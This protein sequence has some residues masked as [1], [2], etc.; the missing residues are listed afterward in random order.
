MKGREKIKE[1]HLA[2]S[3][4]QRP[5][6]DFLFPHDG[7][8]VD[9]SDN[10][11]L[12]AIA[13]GDR[14]AF[15]ILVRRYLSKKVTLAQIIVF[16]PDQAREIAQEAFLR[17]WLNAAKWD[18]DGSAMFSTWLRRVV[19]NLSISQRRRRREQISIDAIADLP[20]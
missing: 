14:E 1:D 19:I 20:D 9:F 13:E 10:D 2:P 18:P 5:V 12:E 17:V 4:P 6:T 7:L 15:T 8:R 3:A 16:Y 11:L